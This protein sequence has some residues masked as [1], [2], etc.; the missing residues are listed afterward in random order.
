MSKRKVYLD[1]AATT[2]VYPEVVKVM[3]PF[4]TKKFGNPSS[5]HYLGQEARMAIDQARG[6]VAELLGAE[7]P[8]IIFTGT[9]TTSTNIAIQGVAQAQR[10]QGNHLITASIEHR[11]V[12]DVVKALEKQGFTNTILGV[13]KFGVVD[14][15]ALERAITSK[16][17]LVTIMY[18]NNEVGTIQP[19]KNIARIIRKKEKELKTKI[20]FHV[21]AATAVG[22]LDIKV[23]NLGVDLLTLGSH[24]FG[25]PKGVGILYLKKGTPLNFIFFG[26]HHEKGI[27]PGT[28]PTPLII[29]MTRALEISLKDEK[30][31]KPRVKALR[32]RL[33]KGILQIPNTQL[34]GHPQ[35]RLADIASFIIKRVEGEAMLLLLSDEGIAASSGSA[36]T[37]GE[38]KPSHVLTSMGISPEDAHGSLR[39]SLGGETTQEEIDY[40]IQVLPEVV[41]RLRKMR[42]G[43]RI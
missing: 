3:A 35:K 36:C 20:Y 29:G 27:W 6:K 15:K 23:E 25:G 31:V 39:F 14:L 41:G 43:I 26:G 16:T 30:K 22:W 7:P 42:R 18:A 32:D 33:I 1:Y 24:K 9:T 37:S 38:L 13:D 12:L 2:P 10:K 8:E 4:W 34:T 11:G 5:V 28:E 17:T 19:I 21:D 40:V